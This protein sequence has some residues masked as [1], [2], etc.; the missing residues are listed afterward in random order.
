ML[1]MI[2]SEDTL[3]GPKSVELLARAYRQRGGLSDVTLTVYPGGRHEM[4]NEINQ[5]E[6]RADIIAWLDAHYPAR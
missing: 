6:V 1:I 3:G 5:D 2:G 4:L